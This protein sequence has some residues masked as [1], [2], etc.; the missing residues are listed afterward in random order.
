[1]LNGGAIPSG[2]L[3][4]NHLKA[5]NDSNCT[6]LFLPQDKFYPKRDLKARRLRQ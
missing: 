4:F 3:F 1:M 5:N 6:N 2:V